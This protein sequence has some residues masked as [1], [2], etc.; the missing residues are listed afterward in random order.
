MDSVITVSSSD[1]TS[2]WLCSCSHILFIYF[3]SSVGSHPSG[4]DIKIFDFKDKE[5][6]IFMILRIP[7]SQN[8]WLHQNYIFWM[9]EFNIEVPI[10]NLD[11]GCLAAWHQR[12]RS[13]FV[14]LNTCCCFIGCFHILLRSS[15]ICPLSSISHSSKHFFPASLR[16]AP[17]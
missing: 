15:V 4:V 6:M 9:H 17:T 11:P 8:F 13:Q 3:Y 2:W 5:M 1:V 14:T 16:E 12:S 7:W 10:W